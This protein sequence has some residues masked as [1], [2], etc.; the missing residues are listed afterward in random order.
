MSISMAGVG[1]GLPINDWIDALI[2][3]EKTSLNNYTNEKNSI[4]ISHNRNNRD[5]CNL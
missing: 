3:S 1:S 4:N 2:H 5:Q